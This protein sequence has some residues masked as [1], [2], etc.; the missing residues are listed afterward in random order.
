MLT[1]RIPYYSN[2]VRRRISFPGG[3]SRSASASRSWC[4]SRK[5][6]TTA[7]AAA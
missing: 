2:G 1:W 3:S 6:L 7:G 4:R 5:V